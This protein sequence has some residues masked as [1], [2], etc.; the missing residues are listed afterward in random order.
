RTNVQEYAE[1]ATGMN[2]LNPATGI[3]EPSIEQFHIAKNGHAVATNGQFQLIISPVIN[4]AE[5]AVHLLSPDGKLFSSTILG[6]N[7]YNR[8]TGESLLIGELTNSV[9]ELVAPNQVLFRNCFDALDA[10]VRLTYRRGSFH[11][12]VVLREA[13][14]VEQLGALGFSLKKTRLEIWTEFIAAPVP[15]ITRPQVEWASH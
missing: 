8:F 15:T 12:D 2:H 4:D 5:G 11:Q 10:D 6:M 14:D 9:G 3:W 1:I 13:P 7:L